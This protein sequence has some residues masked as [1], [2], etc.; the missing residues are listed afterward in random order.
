[1]IKMTISTEYEISGLGNKL[2]D[3]LVDEDQ[4][5]NIENREPTEFWSCTIREHTKE[6]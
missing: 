4:I 6:R 5:C 1:M 3:D 2:Q